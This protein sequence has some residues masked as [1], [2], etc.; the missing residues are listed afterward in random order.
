MVSLPSCLQLLVYMEQ[1]VL[2]LFDA[3]FVQH[4]HWQWKKMSTLT[5]LTVNAISKNFAQ[6]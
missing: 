3:V 4:G 6:P 2:V 5:I 1:I